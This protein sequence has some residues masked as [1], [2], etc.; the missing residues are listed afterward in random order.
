MCVHAVEIASNVKNYMNYV[1]MTF[2]L[3]FTEILRK[4]IGMEIWKSIATY[5]ENI[6]SRGERILD[7]V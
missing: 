5:V 6:E 3:L 4:C 7:D 2:F 1:Y